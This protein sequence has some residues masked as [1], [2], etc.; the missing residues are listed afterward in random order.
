MYMHTYTIHAGAGGRGASVN[1]GVDPL[2]AGAA[3]VTACLLL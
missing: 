2:W 1:T 3:G